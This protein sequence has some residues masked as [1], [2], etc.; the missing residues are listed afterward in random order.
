[1]HTGAV[2]TKNGLQLASW[3]WI[4]LEV[5]VFIGGWVTGAIALPF[6]RKLGRNFKW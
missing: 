4:E 5:S 6:A 1:M 3:N 2:M